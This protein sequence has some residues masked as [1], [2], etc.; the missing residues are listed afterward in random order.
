ME[1]GKKIKQLRFKAS[2]TQEQLAERLG[3]SAQ[4]VSKWEN[5]VAMPDISTLP[6]LAEI[7]GVTIDDLFDL[8]SE[9]RLNRIENRLDAED[10]LPQDVFLEYEAFLQ[11]ELKVEAHKQRATDLLAYLYWHRMESYGRK[12]SRYA[13]EGVRMNP[14]VK[15]SQWILCKTDGHVCWDW[16]MGNHTDAIDFYRELV[17]ANPT[18]RSPYLY[19]IDNLLADHRADEAEHYLA[20]LRT[21]P[22]ANPIMNEI[23]RAHIALARFD[24][25]TADRII[26]ELLAANPENDVCLFEAAQYYAMKCDYDRAIELYERSFEAEPRRPRFQD[27]LMAIAQIH[28]IRGDYKKAAETYDRII[29]LLENE[30]GLTEETDSGVTAAKREKA[31]LLAKA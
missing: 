13:K 8:S 27:E 19:L 4:S 18:V 7:F 1:L 6:L 5:A 31:R 23:Y 15:C 12:A 9:Q 24:A 14:G 21:L 17:E 16:N 25:P 28:E 3:I 2:L 20:R 22:D 26:E 11:N 30:W 29:D 10:N